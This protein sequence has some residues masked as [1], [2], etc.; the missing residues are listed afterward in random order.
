MCLVPLRVA[1]SFKI[2]LTKKRLLVRL[3]LFWIPVFKESF[4]IQGKYLVC[5]G[6]VDADIDLTTVNGQ[7]GINLAKAIV[8]DSVNVTF[9]VDY[10][11][12]NPAVMPVVEGT[13]FAATTTA[14][15]LTNCRVHTN[16]CFSLEN[17]VFGE[18]VLSTTLAEIL[19][20]LVKEKVKLWT[21]KSAQ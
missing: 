13:L 16:N 10:T 14:C 21:N 20:A 1:A 5:K 19:L 3:T 11:K 8:V 15:A 2:D 4:I 6:T 9:A 7:S 18:V 12:T 17:A